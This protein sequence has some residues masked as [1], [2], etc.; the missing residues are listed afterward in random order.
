MAC[1]KS[2]HH[3][4]RGHSQ[5]NVM[6]IN[7]HGNLA[8]LHPHT[9]V[10]LHCR[11]F[12]K[13]LFESL[14]RIDLEGK[15][16]LAAAEKVEISP[17]QTIYTFTLRPMIWSNHE[18]VTAYQF[19]KTWKSVLTSNSMAIRADL[20][21]MIKNA[22]KAKKNLISMD[23]VGISAQDEKT[24]I[25]ELEHPAPYFLELIANPIFSPLYD[26]SKTPEVF[27]G[28]FKLVKWDHDKKMVLEKNPDYWDKKSVSLDQIEVSFIPDPMTALML[29]EKG[30]LDWV[31]HPFTQLPT[32]ALAK[33]EESEDFYSHP[34]AAVYWFFINTEN[35]PLHSAKLRKALSMALDREALCKHVLYGETPRKSVVPISTN[36]LDE[37]ELYSD[38]NQEAAKILFHEALEELELSLATFPVLTFN[39]SDI[40]GQKRLVEAIQRCWEL[41][42][43]I[44]VQLHNSEWNLFF[45]NFARR[46]FQIGGCI[47]YSAF[48]DPIYNLEF[49][50]EKKYKF[51]ACQWENAHYQELLELADLEIDYEKRSEYLKEAEKLLLDEMPIIPLFVAHAKYLKSPKIKNMNVSELGQTDFKWAYYDSVR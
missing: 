12:Q 48:N 19:E 21:Y 38:N 4:K 31:G 51:N 1:Q 30:E 49:F 27:N 8:S 44:K 23:A 15:P 47:W 3:E 10:D 25:V 17:D 50:K 16:V 46:D 45:A 24:F 26:E 11:I 43:G 18:K 36:L 5:L 42:F 33:L 32:D 29:Y 22:E 40:P 13:A 41:T 9:G 35:P 28:P 14:T 6:R 7:N 34:L 20:F 37:D 2:H 39:H